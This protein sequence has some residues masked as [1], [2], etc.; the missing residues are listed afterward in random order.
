[1]VSV[2]TFSSDDSSSDPAEVHNNFCYNESTNTLTL[3]LKLAQM[4]R[5]NKEKL[6][7]NQ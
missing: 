5:F 4:K 1:M 6:E 2:L 7:A 3:E